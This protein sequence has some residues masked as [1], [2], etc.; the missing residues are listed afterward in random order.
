[1]RLI[2]IIPL[3]L[4]MLILAGKAAGQI[5]SPEASDSFGAAYNGAGGTDK[6]F[7]Y[8]VEKYLQPKTISIIAVPE[9]GLSGWNFDWSVYV[10]TAQ[11]YNTIPG[12]STGFSSIVD[13]ITVTSGYQV[14]MTKGSITSVYRVWVVFNDFNVTITNKDADNK[15][16][17]GSYYCSSLDLR[18]DTT[19]YPSYY[20]NPVN[21]NRIKIANTYTIRWTTD[22]PEASIP[23]SRFNT[24]VTNQPVEDTWY[25]INVTDRFKLLR[26]DSVL[27]ESIQSEASINKTY[28]PLNNEGY[29]GKNY[30]MYYRGDEGSAS[31]PGRFR[32]DISGSKNAASYE[33]KFGDGEILVTDSAATDIEH[34]YKKPGK[35]IVTLTTKSTK[36]YECID[37]ATVEAVLLYGLFDLP[38][39]FTP[40]NDYTID[41]YKE[42]GENDIFRSLDISVVT[43]DIAIFD[44]AGTKM[45]T[46]SGDI[47][48]WK[49]WDG[50]VKDSNRDAPEGV[51]FWVVSSLIYFS[52]PNPN[53]DPEK[54]GI[55]KEDYSGFFHLYRE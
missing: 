26:S 7:I 32:F 14:M 17:F 3:I 55:T 1:M 5:F 53:P 29:P 35:Y 6:V 23:P 21:G 41:N 37:S 51:Y 43:I 9:D 25:K 24:R 2:K 47:R 48:D 33:L 45:H 30:E 34:E 16:E 44:R 39:V 15:L 28:V 31:A 12:T 18:S 52:D 8:N 54:Q 27:Y 10:P 22:N 38:N 40:D 19:A 4:V 46:Y 36:P 13:T 20:F 49:G 42:G 50:R 11:A